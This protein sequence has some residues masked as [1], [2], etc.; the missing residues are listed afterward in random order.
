[1]RKHKQTIQPKPA[2]VPKLLRGSL[3]RL[4]RKCG[5]PNCRCCHG[6][7]HASPALSY[8]QRGLTKLLTLPPGWTRPVRRSLQRYQQRQRR[9]ERQA[10]AGL[11][12]LARQLRRARKSTPAR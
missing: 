3:F 9:L 10:E 6:P 11:R 8:S 1:M 4:R 2:R 7:P 5:K 12:Q